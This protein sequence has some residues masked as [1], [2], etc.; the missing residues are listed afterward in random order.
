LYLEFFDL[1][2]D[3]SKIRKGRLVSREKESKH[4]SHNLEP[5]LS[6]KSVHFLFNEKTKK[7]REYGNNNTYSINVA[8]ITIVIM[9]MRIILKFFQ[10]FYK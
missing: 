10:I 4:L 9:R 8:E 6:E 1:W 2:F 5:N 3:S 7:S